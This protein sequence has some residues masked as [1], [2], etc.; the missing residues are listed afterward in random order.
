MQNWLRMFS[1]WGEPIRNGQLRQPLSP[2]KNLQMV[3]VDAIGCVC[4]AC[5]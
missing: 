5:V 2:T 3:A 4:S 1:Y